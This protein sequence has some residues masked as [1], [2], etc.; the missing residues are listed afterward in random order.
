MEI[1]QKLGSLPI[2][3]LMF[4]VIYFL[5]IRP[6]SVQQKKHKELLDQLK[7]GDKVI[8]NS[9]LIGKIVDI[10]G[11]NKD[12]VILSTSNSTNITILKSYII[13]LDN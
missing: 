11:K 12:R 10:Q 13:S 9:G 8:T 6:Q 5:M 7:K 1:L 3:I 4:V 2:F